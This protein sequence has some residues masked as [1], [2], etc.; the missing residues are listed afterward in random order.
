MLILLYPSQNS[1]R[2]QMERHK[3][4]K[5][6]RHYDLGFLPESR[7]MATIASDQVT[8]SA[9]AHSSNLLSSASLDTCAAQQTTNI[10]QRTGSQTPREFSAQPADLQACT[11]LR[12]LWRPTRFC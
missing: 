6:T 1:L 11:D 5:L 4:D 7:K 8:G 2:Y 3:P 12:E 10:P 9:S